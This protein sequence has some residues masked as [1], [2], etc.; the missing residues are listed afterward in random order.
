MSTGKRQT[1]M[2]VSQPATHKKMRVVRETSANQTATITHGCAQAYIRP[3]YSVERWR[4]LRGVRAVT[5]KI[6]KA[7]P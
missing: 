6:T 2:R 1:K 7:G 3:V 4:P 5:F